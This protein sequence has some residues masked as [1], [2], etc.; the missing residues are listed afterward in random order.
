MSTSPQPKLKLEIHMSS[1]CSNQGGVSLELNAP[2]D[3]YSEWIDACETVAQ[4]D[5]DEQLS[6][7]SKPTAEDRNFSTYG[8]REDGRQA[9][10]GLGDDGFINDDDF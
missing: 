3:V 4:K 6:R 7:T 1:G 9:G 5:A 10:V 2:V 8:S